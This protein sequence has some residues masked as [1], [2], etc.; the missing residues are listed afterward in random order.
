MS[1][2]FVL[3]MLL[4]AALLSA[5]PT[6]V[7]APPASAGAIQSGL[8]DVDAYYQRLDRTMRQPGKV[9]AP[10]SGDV[11]DG[12]RSETPSDQATPT[13]PAAG[14]L[15][16]SRIAVTESHV[17][18]HDQ[19]AALTT[20]LEQ[21]TV[22][23]DE[24]LDLVDRINA[25][26]RARNLVTA[27]AKLPPQDVVDGVVRIELIE[28]RI[29]Q[30]EIVE[31]RFT[32]EGYIARRLDLHEGAFADPNVLE[33][34]LLAFN[35]VND[36][37]IRALLRPGTKPNT[38]RYVLQ[39]LEPQNQYVSLFAD[40]AGRETI[41]EE[42]VGLT[43]TNN[44]LM[45]RRDRLSAGASFADGADAGFVVYSTPLTRHGTRVILGFDYS[46]IVIV[47]GELATFDVTGRSTIA[48]AFLSHPLK[49]APRWS[50]SGL[51]GID[52]KDSETD[53]NGI[54]R[55]ESAVRT[56]GVGA[57]YQWF[58]NGY[59]V[60]ARPQLSFGV[61]RFGGDSRFATLDGEA[62]AIINAGFSHQL[63][64]R[65]RGQLSSSD[66]LPSAE[67]FQMGGTSSVRGFPEG[68]L[69]GDKGYFVSAEYRYRGFSGGS[70]HSVQPFVFADHGGVSAASGAPERSRYLTSAGLGIACRLFDK[71]TANVQVGFPIG[72][73]AGFDGDYAV[74]FQLSYMPF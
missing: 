16:V 74:H 51:V 46:Q 36:V 32:R 33:D 49:V 54:D 71:V 62:G 68:L 63:A 60:Y 5:S 43:Y 56:F 34:E 17:L 65:L 21:R 3:P 27:R 50:L 6:V 12:P 7:A 41:G 58:G 4:S 59:L 45:G 44:S 18:S 72:D 35:A 31:N 10:V 52:F 73:R 2:G 9:G 29:D 13:T 42:R 25:L 40:N 55:F 39:A 66:R 22:A 20:P 53:F 15:R 24:L 30:V 64:L 28:A 14:G 11:I 67:Q 37:Q 38:T 1:R 70:A 61:K 57:E 8:R 19:L 69:I 23:L 26:Y 47:S 48:S